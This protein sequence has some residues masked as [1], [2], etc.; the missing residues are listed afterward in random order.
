L[1]GWNEEIG[2]FGCFAG[3]NS[4]SAHKQGKSKDCFLKYQYFLQEF[5]MWKAFTAIY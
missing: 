2:D 1:D 4:G 3:V 5:L